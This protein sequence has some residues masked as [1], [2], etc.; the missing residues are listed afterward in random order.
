MIKSFA[1]AE[2]KAQMITKSN[3]QT[4]KKKKITN[5]YTTQKKNNQTQNEHYFRTKDSTIQITIRVEISRRIIKNII[6]ALSL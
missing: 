3:S 2:F 5:I 4:K 6:T 1:R